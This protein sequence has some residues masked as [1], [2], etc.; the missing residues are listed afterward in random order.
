MAHSLAEVQYSK[1]ANGNS[2]MAKLLVLEIISQSHR[3]AVCIITLIGLQ[4]INVD[5]LASI[6]GA[7]DVTNDSF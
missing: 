3:N 5:I 7:I 6:A 4:S 2:W 1:L